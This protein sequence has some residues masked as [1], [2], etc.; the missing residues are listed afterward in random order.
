MT[1]MFLGRSVSFRGCSGPFWRL[2]DDSVVNPA[3]LGP[4]GVQSLVVHVLMSPRR[5]GTSQGVN[6]VVSVTGVK[7]REPT[8]KGSD[9]RPSWDDFPCYLHALP[10]AQLLV[11]LPFSFSVKALQSSL[12]SSGQ[13]NPPFWSKSG[14]N[15]HVG[16][17]GNKRMVDLTGHSSERSRAGGACQA[18][19]HACE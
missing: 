4:V 12:K 14:W 19:A 1:R 11:A 15:H 16:A 6:H 7:N 8:E 3:K 18:R 17:S 13:S 9:A 5:F 10:A 2:K